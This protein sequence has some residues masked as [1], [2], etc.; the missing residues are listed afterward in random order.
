MAPKPSSISAL[1]ACRQLGPGAGGLAATLARLTQGLSGLPPGDGGRLVRQGGRNARDGMAFLQAAEGILREVANH[2][3]RAAGLVARAQT[4]APQDTARAQ[5]E[6]EFQGLIKGIAELGLGATFNGLPL[7]SGGHG[8][9]LAIGPDTRVRVALGAIATSPRAAL[10]LAQGDCSIAS[11]AA[12][13]AAGATVAAAQA[14]V[15]VLRAAL[16][17]TMAQLRGHADRC[18]LQVANHTALA[19]LPVAESA[20]EVVQLARFQILSRSGSLA[21]GPAQQAILALLG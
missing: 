4:E 7:F 18:A 3:A 6:R 10:G 20:A 13:G 1:G 5:L 11:Q 16:G 2:L 12:A 17:E 15:E 14:S 9:E 21:P 8:L 19:G